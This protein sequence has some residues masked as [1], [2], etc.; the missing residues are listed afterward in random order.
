MKYENA[1][2]EAMRASARDG[3]TTPLREIVFR[4]VLRAELQSPAARVQRGS[5][6]DSAKSGPPLVQLAERWGVEP[7]Q[8]ENLY[9]FSGDTV[10]LAIDPSRLA[11]T[12]TG[13]TEQI[14][15]LVSAARQVGL[16]ESET[17]VDEIRRVCS[18]YGR[19]DESNFAASLKPLTG[20]AFFGGSN[21]SRTI[22]LNKAGLERAKQIALAV[23]GAT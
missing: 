10:S 16:R 9:E 17:N 5:V 21:R 8:I 23:L 13:A 4:E 15:Y 12:K 14:A 19:Y 1:I 2:D 20:N 3:L 11:P 18:D 7:S 6:I 22:R